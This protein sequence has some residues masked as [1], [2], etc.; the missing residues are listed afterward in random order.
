VFSIGVI[1]FLENPHVAIQKL[2]NAAKK[3]G[4]VLIWVYAHEGNEWIVKYI[5]PIRSITSRLP[6]RMTD[7]FA[8]LLSIPLYVFLKSIPQRHPYFRQLSKNKFWHIHS[9]VFDQL[10]PRVA[11]YWEREEALSLFEGKGLENIQIHRVNE[12]SWTVLGK[13][14]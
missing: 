2:V 12:N 9:I 8:R 11:N 13:K 6:L 1:M 5:N 10:I 3:G 7:I 4:T 14:V